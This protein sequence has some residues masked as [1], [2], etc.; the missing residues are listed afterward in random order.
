MHGRHA[1]INCINRAEEQ[2]VTAPVQWFEWPC[3]TY[4]L[5]GQPE[6]YMELLIS[7]GAL[8]NETVARPLNFFDRISVCRRL[9]LKDFPRGPA[10]YRA[11]EELG[12]RKK[13]DQAKRDFRAKIMSTWGVQS[14]QAGKWRDIVN[15]ESGVWQR[16]EKI[17]QGLFHLLFLPFFLFRLLRTKNG[18]I[19]KNYKS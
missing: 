8:D 14:G 13:K 18:K 15:V 5:P 3:F 17:M 7:I 1:V 6:D 2:N 10:D 16:Y 9:Y 11:N 12:P 19:K 4:W